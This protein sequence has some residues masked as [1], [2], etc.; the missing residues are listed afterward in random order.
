MTTT[1][2]QPTLPHRSSFARVPAVFRLQFAVRYSFIWLPM[3]IFALAWVLGIGIGFF[4]DSQ[5]P[6]RIPAEDPIFSTGA[7]QATIWYLAFMA[8]Y[9]AS[10]TFPFSLALSYSRRVYVIGTYLAF[11]VVAAGYGVATMLAYYIERVTEGFGRHIYVFG[12]PSF[13]N[14]GGGFGI[15]MFAAVIVL[16]FMCF[17]FFWAILYRRVTIPILWTV[18][19]GV[20]VAI[21][22]TVVVIT[23]NDWWPNIGQWLTNQNAFTLAGWGFLAVILL[24]AVNYL[25][26]RKATA[27]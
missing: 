5:M 14:L 6:D 22:G 2:P 9:T 21:L 4:I 18:I 3:F 15:G 11:V 24:G 10:H 8:A 13:E 25:L 12:P 16:F 23:L 20:I 1:T 27:G 26:I 7:A 17:G 19:I